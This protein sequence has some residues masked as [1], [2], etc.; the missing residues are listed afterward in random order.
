MS[1]NNSLLF[2]VIAGAVAGVAIGLLF[3]PEKG[4]DTQQ[5]ITDTAKNL[6]DKIM[7]KAEELLKETSK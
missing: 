4:S 6:A 1:N 3:A 2:A 5:K 7:Q